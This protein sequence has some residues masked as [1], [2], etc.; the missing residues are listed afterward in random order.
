MNRMATAAFAVIYQKARKCSFE[1]AK[2]QVL[3]GYNHWRSVVVFVKPNEV[4][5]ARVAAKP[6]KFVTLSNIW[7]TPT[8][9]KELN[10]SFTSTVTGKPKKKRN[11]K[12]KQ[13]ESTTECNPPKKRR[14]S[15][16]STAD[17][18]ESMINHSA[19]FMQQQTR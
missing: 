8:Q 16:T 3:R 2:F 11:A 7:N 9:I 12:Q 5:M 18:N 15:Q 14:I 17:G 19:M 4:L 6:P 13:K 1:F 10:Q